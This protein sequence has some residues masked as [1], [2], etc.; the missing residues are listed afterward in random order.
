MP[1]VVRTDNMSMMNLPSGNDREQRSGL[2][3][4]TRN[5]RI[6]LIFFFVLALGYAGWQYAVQRRAQL[7]LGEDIP[8]PSGGIVVQVVGAVEHP[9]LV[10]L[11][12]DARVSDAIEAA[13]G[14]TSEADT[15]A[16]D[17]TAPLVDGQRIVVPYL[18]E[19]QESRRFDNDHAIRIPWPSERNSGGSAQEA[20]WPVNIN[21][22]GSVELQ[23]LP[24]IG[25]QLA[26]RIIEYRMRHGPFRAIEDIMEVEG[27]GESRFEA[28]RDKITVGG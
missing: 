12:H 28:I 2:F 11:P 16:V 19:T 20:S 23:T 24:G 26:E 4:L 15:S 1:D 5:E 17:L 3:T 18:D 27:I 14:F 6:A 9:D 10:Y 22:A 8:Y 13:G 7:N 25:E 21:T